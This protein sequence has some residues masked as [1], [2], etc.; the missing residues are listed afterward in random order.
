MNKFKIL[1]F[2]FIFSSCASK[3]DVVYLKDIDSNFQSII[4][5]A[6]EDK[7][8]IGDI[9]Q[10]KVSTLVP[11]ASIPYN[12]E[13][14]EI[15][16][17]DKTNLMLDGYIVDNFYDINLPVLGKINVES[18]SQRQL[19]EKIKKLLVDGDHLIHPT[20]NVRR[21]NSKFTVL[22]EVATPGTFSFY[23]DRINIFQALGY[24]GDL[25]IDAKRNKI[26]LIRENNGIRKIF[27]IELTKSDLMNKPFFYIKNNDVI[28]VSPNFSK[29]KSAGFIGSPSSIASIASLLL[30]ITLLIINN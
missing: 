18:L 12:K 8:S 23:D 16:Q 26:K 20:V 29:T 14:K 19:S 24:A 22:G 13:S 28:I 9:L 15:S 17:K 4:K 11:E 10:I 2:L 27:E 6:N 1:L 3:K 5:I 30:S 21:V 25:T 7:I